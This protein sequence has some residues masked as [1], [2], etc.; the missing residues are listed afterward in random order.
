MTAASPFTF[1]IR[2]PADVYHAKSR[3]YLSSHKLADFRRCPL[4]FRRKQLGLIQDVDRP[5]YLVG[6]A[7]HTLIL[8]GRSR[9]DAKYAVGGPINEKTGKPYGSYTKAFAEWSASQGKDVLTEDQAVLVEQMYASVCGH[10]RAAL[11]LENGIAEGV[12]RTRHLDTECQARPDW[13]TLH[14]GHAAIIDLK[15]CDD[16]DWFE[17]DAR[18]F[19]YAHQLAFYRSVIW[20][21]ID[22][23]LPVHIIAVEKKDPFRTGVWIVSQDVLSLAQAENESAMRRLRQCVQTDHWPTGYEEVRVFDHL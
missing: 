5:A 21:V 23:L 4:L 18:R 9:F 1:L 20:Q 2:E 11:L 6:R 17:S 14:N 15:T 16:L 7:A 8:E 22:E 19:G 10:D 12:V 3:Q 13:L